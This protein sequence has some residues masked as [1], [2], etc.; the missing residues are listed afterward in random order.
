ME[1]ESQQCAMNGRS[2][3]AMIQLKKKKSDTN[4]TKLPQRS[5]CISYT[6]VNFANMFGENIVFHVFNNDISWN[7]LIKFHFLVNSAQSWLFGYSYKSQFYLIFYNS[8][9]NTP[10]GLP[11]VGELWKNT[12]FL[13]NF[14]YW[15]KNPCYKIF[16]FDFNCAQI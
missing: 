16:I 3:S 4:F 7:F 13:L 9:L 6:N 5:L 8:T 15:E 10:L 12:W 2:S 14:L 1:V 11:N